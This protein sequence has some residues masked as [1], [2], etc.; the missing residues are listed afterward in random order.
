MDRDTA[1]FGGISN[2]HLSDLEHLLCNKLGHRVI[3]I[4]DTQRD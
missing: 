4:L 1:N 2:A 3:A